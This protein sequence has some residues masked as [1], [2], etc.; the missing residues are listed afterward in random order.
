M[1][2]VGALVANLE[3]NSAGFEA[4]LEKA[5]ASVGPCIGVGA[6]GVGA[7]RALPAP[8]SAFWPIPS[9]LPP[10]TDVVKR[11]NLRRLLAICGGSGAPPATVSIGWK[12]E[13]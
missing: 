7:G 10:R 9:A 11:A 5:S 4:D 2:T 6:P 8:V 12:A 13:V 3:A 1:A